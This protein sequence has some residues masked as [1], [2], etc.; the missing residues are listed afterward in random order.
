MISILLSA[1]QS[2]PSTPSRD[3]DVRFSG[4]PLKYYSMALWILRQTFGVKVALSGSLQPRPI[5][6]LLIAN[7]RCYLTC[8]RRVVRQMKRL[9]LGCPNTLLSLPDGQTSVAIH[10]ARSGR[11]AKAVS[12]LCGH[13]SRCARNSGYRRAQRSITFGFQGRLL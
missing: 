11:S 3:L 9:G 13:V 10:Y 6:S 5:I 4:A 12:I 7:M 1:C 2:Q 8:S